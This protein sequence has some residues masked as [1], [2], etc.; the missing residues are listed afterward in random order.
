MGQ[1]GK[2]AAYNKTVKY[3]I[4]FPLNLEERYYK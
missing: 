4:I 1:L 2:S 3:Y